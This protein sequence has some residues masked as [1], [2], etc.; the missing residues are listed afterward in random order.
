MLTSPHNVQ[1]TFRLNCAPV[2]RMDVAQVYFL[3]TRCLI[4][5]A[6]GFQLFCMAMA[7]AA[8]EA[9]RVIFALGTTYSFYDQPGLKFLH[10]GI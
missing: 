8:A 2:E 3:S 5:G 6:K 10:S 1:V 9:G 7:A 4:L